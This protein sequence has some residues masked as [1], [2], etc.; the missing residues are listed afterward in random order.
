MKLYFINYC[1]RGNL[2]KTLPMTKITHIVVRKTSVVLCTESARHA[3]FREIFRSGPDTVTTVWS[4]PAITEQICHGVHP[5]SSGVNTSM[6]CVFTLT[7]HKKI[8]FK[9]FIKNICY[10]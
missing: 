3:T 2:P 5:A 8:I 4:D 6:A 1:Y 9:C 7:P 10:F